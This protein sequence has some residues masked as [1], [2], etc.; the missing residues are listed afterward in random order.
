MPPTP[1]PMR[2][3][4]VT[5]S[6]ATPSRLTLE[7]P[8]KSSTQR[9]LRSTHQTPRTMLSSL[10][11]TRTLRSDYTPSPSNGMKQPGSPLDP[12]VPRNSGSR[13]R[14]PPKRLRRTRSRTTSQT[15]L[16]STPDRSLTQKD[17]DG[18]GRPS[19]HD[20]ISR[21]NTPSRSSPDIK[22]TPLFAVPPPT[23]S[24]G[25]SITEPAG[26]TF[27]SNSYRSESTHP[28]LAGEATIWTANFPLKPFDNN[29]VTTMSSISTATISNADT[30]MGIGTGMGM[31]Y[32]RAVTP[33]DILLHAATG[34]SYESPLFYHDPL[35]TQL[36]DPFLTPLPPPHSPV[37]GIST[38]LSIHNGSGLGSDYPGVLVY[39]HNL[40]ANDH[41][42]DMQP[43]LDPNPG[44]GERGKEL[45][46][47]PE[48]D[49][50]FC[51][52][53]LVKDMETFGSTPVGA[54][55][56]AAATEATKG[57]EAGLEGQLG[58]GKDA[59]MGWESEVG[60]GLSSA[61]GGT[62]MR[63]EVE[64]E[65]EDVRVSPGQGQGGEDSLGRNGR[66]AEEGADGTREGQDGKKEQLEVVQALPAEP[67][68]GPETDSALLKSHPN[69]DPKSRIGT[70]TIMG[71]V[72]YPSPTP[73]PTFAQGAT[74]AY[75][76]GPVSASPV[77]EGEASDEQMRPEPYALAF[78]PARAEQAVIPEVIV[79]TT[80]SESIEQEELEIKDIVEPNAIQANIEGKKVS[81]P[82]DDPRDDSPLP[83]SGME[84]DTEPGP[85]T[86]KVPTFKPTIHQLLG[87]SEPTSDEELRA[88][89]MK[90]P[91]KRYPS[92]R[93]PSAT[94]TSS[95]SSSPR[96]PGTSFSTTKSNSST[97]DT[98]DPHSPCLRTQVKRKRRPQPLQLRA[99]SRNPN[100]K[101]LVV[102]PHI[103]EL[104]NEADEKE[105]DMQDV[106]D[107]ES[108]L[109][110]LPEEIS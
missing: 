84:V 88:M 5:R 6:S 48:L 47:E 105:I 87:A 15:F 59:E 79:G 8:R 7:T 13:R 44:L 68:E 69:V 97:K 52:S 109:T 38:P 54:Y 28:S 22:Y 41:F 72:D 60:M 2:D 64:M 30:G 65:M 73:S 74:P 42:V 101:P 86:E 12:L 43:S 17:G 77:Q 108:E 31:A 50:Y 29:T 81:W 83:G 21:L 94:P 90:V 107:A 34:I 95:S 70:S 19:Y 57:S 76:L 9:S 66:A 58:G 100:A 26:A 14:A 61:G 110:P 75:M 67:T 102:K 3:R 91:D 16:V 55:F 1:K 45:G 98:T 27:K 37:E 40:N 104:L 10:T 106:S 46:L 51:F 89:I 56:Q 85:R 82:S 78:A 25:C 39:E 18:D 11:P 53:P 4:P 23:E 103:H 62:D 35:V 33:Q 32:P 99:P 96:R 63:L 36:H 49:L 20:P 93:W 92:R 80:V 24:T 71:L